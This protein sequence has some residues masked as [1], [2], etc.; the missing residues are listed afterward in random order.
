MCIST[1]K[2]PIVKLTFMGVHLDL[3]YCAMISPVN[4]LA[5]E[6]AASVQSLKDTFLLEIKNAMPDKTNAM[7]FS[8]WK[9][10]Q[11]LLSMIDDPESFS[12]S[13]KIVKRWAKQRG[14]YGFNFGYLN[15]I[16]LVIMLIKAHRYLQS[17]KVQQ[18]KQVVT[19]TKATRNH[20]DMSSTMASQSG[21][22]PGGKML[23]KPKL[24]SINKENTI[25]ELVSKFFEVFASWDYSKP[26]FVQ[27]NAEC[28]D[29]E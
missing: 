8:G 6:T 18:C 29:G 27:A 7:S 15:G 25:T 19:Q 11:A 17:D 5:K 22:Y 4:L 10:C 21:F 3:L 16:S 23:E 14:V 28:M 20:F 24:T 1:A 2:I 12:M 13:L 26:I 9:T